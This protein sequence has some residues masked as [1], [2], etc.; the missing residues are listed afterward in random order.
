MSIHKNCLICE[1]IALIKNGKNPYFVT[2]LESGYIVLG[3]YQY[4]KGYSLL[5][6]KKHTGELH[7]LPK[8]FRMK[9]LEEMSILAEAV[10]KTFNP[11]KLNYELLGNTDSH[12]H[13][14][15]F[16]RYKDDP[17]KNT[18]TWVIDKS[19]RYSDKAKPTKEELNKLKSKLLKEITKLK[20]VPNKAY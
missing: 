3:D 11:E 16:P 2:K 1:R 15:I 5:L 8:K 20:P 10:Y 13:W 17:N 7:N 19:I 14:H 6:C 4:Y 9:F 12:L 18:V